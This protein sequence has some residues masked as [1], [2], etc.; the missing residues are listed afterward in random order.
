MPDTLEPQN[1]PL[2]VQR[3]VIITPPDAPLPNARFTYV[4]DSPVVV[5]SGEFQIDHRGVVIGAFTMVLV[6]FL[7]FWMPLFG[8]LM[9]GAFGGFFAK[10]WG[11]AFAAA[12]FA[13]VA[14]PFL[15]V[16][17]NG[18]TKTGNLGFLLGLTFWQWTIAHAVCMFIGA[19]S[20]VF[21][22][23]RSERGLLEREI[24]TE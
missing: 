4:D 7:T 8:P 11:R 5:R 22:V 24:A 6:S 2:S 20:G 17:L 1:G 12:A 23:P 13:S 14:V 19:A 3:E 16:V 10:R 18:F 15:L 9:A 21:S